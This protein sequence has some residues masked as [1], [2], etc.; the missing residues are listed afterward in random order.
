[1]QKQRR[2]ICWAL[3][4]LV[5]FI[6]LVLL[7]TQTRN[8][9][10]QP[11]YNGLSLAQWLDV[12]YRHRINGYAPAVT[13]HGRARAAAATP[14]QI[15]QAEEAVRA[16]GTNAL[17][18]LLK[19]IS[20]RAS[21]PKRF[22]RGILLLVPMPEQVRGFLWKPSY[23]KSEGLALLAVQGFTLLNTN[24]LPARGTLSKLAGDPSCPQAAKAL[25][26]VTNAPQQ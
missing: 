22:Y 26:A 21:T 6:T 14:E 18:S 11:V 15:H 16:I 24:A 10:T 1:M 4:V 13:S 5:L 8:R 23:T 3:G 7:L 17:P 25:L 19:W 2:A 12:V 9:I 20:Y